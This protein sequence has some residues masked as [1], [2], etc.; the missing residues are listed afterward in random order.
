MNPTK[1]SLHF[2]EFPTIFYEIYRILQ[3]S[4][5]IQDAIFQPDP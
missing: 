4:N 2:F 1:L 5:T 3:S